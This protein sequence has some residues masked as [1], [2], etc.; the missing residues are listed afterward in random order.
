VVWRTNA[1]ISSF[2]FMGLL[3]VLPDSPGADQ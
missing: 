3:S 1:S 2:V